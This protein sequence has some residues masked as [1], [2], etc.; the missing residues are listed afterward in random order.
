MHSNNAPPKDAL[1]SAF[2]AGLRAHGQVV[3]RDNA[4]SATQNE[5]PALGEK[6]LPE[7]ALEE[8][9]E[10]VVEYIDSCGA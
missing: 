9:E 3:P 7:H 8:L 6:R 5:R 10:D 1:T 4:E 2:L